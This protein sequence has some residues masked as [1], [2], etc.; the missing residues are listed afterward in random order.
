LG[1]GT[2]GAADIADD[3]LDAKEIIRLSEGLVM[4]EDAAA[5]SALPA[6]RLAGAR[7]YLYYG[8][9]L[10]SRWH[11][12]R[13]D[14]VDPPNDKELRVKFYTL[15]VPVVGQSRANAIEEAISTSL[16][17]GPTLLLELN[18]QPVKNFQK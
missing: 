17:D 8:Q 18:K 10:E 5:N 15:A 7:L 2:A 14:A 13:W 4:S 12:P 9:V 11:T 3:A 6:R 1:R 16:Q